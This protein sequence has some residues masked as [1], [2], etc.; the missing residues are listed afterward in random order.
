MPACIAPR[1]APPESTNAVA[2]AL[3]LAGEECSTALIRMMLLDDSTNST[4]R[5]LSCQASLA[6]ALRLAPNSSPHG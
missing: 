6:Q 5:Y 4:S 3:L 1:L 2:G